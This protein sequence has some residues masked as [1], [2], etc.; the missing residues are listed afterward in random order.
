MNK[1]Q[2]NKGKDMV[3]KEDS[4]LPAQQRL[5]VI[6]GGPS[7][8]KTT[9]LNALGEK[10]FTVV[11]EAAR[12][13]I[14]QEAAKGVH[15]PTL[16]SSEEFQLTVG[17]L[18]LKREAAV[19]GVAFV[20]RGTPDNLGYHKFYHIRTPPELLDNCK[21]RPYKAVFLLEMLPQFEQ[22]GR[23]E[24]P[25]QA[26]L[27]EQLIEQSYRGLGYR[28]VR[29]PVMSVEERVEFIMKKTELTGTQRNEN[30]TLPVKGGTD[31]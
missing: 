18:Q 4:V 3:Q 6:S 8:G 13:V 26:R 7:C 30:T 2:K 10:G 16:V 17:R 15:I 5:F 27:L 20:D 14:D 25:E 19:S 22:D 11:P 31:G 1:R 24:T 29:V 9:T 21:N 23:T 12:D 28:V